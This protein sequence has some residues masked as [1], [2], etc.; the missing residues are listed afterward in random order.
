MPT[1]VAEKLIDAKAQAI[2]QIA[3]THLGTNVAEPAQIAKL[4]ALVGFEH[5]CI[6]GLNYPGL[7]VGAGVILASDMPKAFLEAYLTEGYIRF[8]PL[9]HMIRPDRPWGSW[10][11]LTDQE[12]SQPELQPIRSLEARFNI[13]LRSCLGL[14]RG[15]VRFGGL[16]FTRATPFSAEEQFMIEAVS[17]WVHQVLSEAYIADMSQRAGISGGEL[18]CL[19]GVAAGFDLLELS[20]S[21]GFAPDTVTTY[22][23]NA[24]RKLGCR[25]RAHAVAEAMRRRLLA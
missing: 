14:Y 22:I 10:H 17:R 7:G 2:A 25:N 6:S 11:A 3:A 8:D 13:S 20:R 18:K 23:K 9:H 1:Y 16:T 21:T 15:T 19:S 4:R 24:I 5:Y 12:L